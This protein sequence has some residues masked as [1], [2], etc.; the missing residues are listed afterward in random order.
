MKKQE[1]M[2]FE[3]EKNQLVERDPG[4]TVMIELA[5]NDFKI[6]IYIYTHMYI[7]GLNESMNIMKRE[8][9]SI[10]ENI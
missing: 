1:N 10:T 7:Q 3:H 4:I 2:T 6:D 5:Y 9:E 8:M